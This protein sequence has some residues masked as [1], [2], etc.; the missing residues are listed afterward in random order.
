MEGLQFTI[1]NIRDIILRRKWIIVWSLI[2]CIAISV[3]LCFTLPKIYRAETLILVTSQKIPEDY[4]KPTVLAEIGERLATLQQ[5][6]FS[7]T[8]LEKI[9]DEFDLYKS[10]RATR[11]MESVIGTMRENIE[12][13]V[14]GKQSFTVV[15]YGRDPETV[16]N[17]TNKL[18]N[19]FIEEN[20]IQRERQARGTTEFL[21]QELEKIEEKLREQ[22]ET[23]SLFK[24]KYRGNLPE[25]LDFNLKVINNLI[26]EGET[27]N[28]A[29]SDAK[30]RKILLQEQLTSMNS[31]VEVVQ[32]DLGTKR[33]ISPQDP[34]KAEL[35]TA[36]RRLFELE[37][38]YTDEHPEVKRLRA[39]I[40]LLDGAIA[41]E[42]QPEG[43]SASNKR[44]P[45]SLYREI[46]TQIKNVDMEIA[47]LEQRVG[48]NRDKVT[49]Y[50]QRV[51]MAPRLEQDIIDITR[52]YDNKKR[53][54]QE[55]LN[56]KMVAEQA[57]NLELMKK[58]E[59]FEILDPA[60]WPERPVEPNRKKLITVGLLL[61][62]ALGSGL[63]YFMEYQNRSFYNTSEVEQSLELPVLASIPKWD[64]LIASDHQ[65]MAS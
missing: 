56:K 54:Y 47:R 65:K 26:A 37:S 61:G 38:I 48:N 13:E 15:Y 4:V 51:A 16:M 8:R 14:T 30:N 9:I 52:D 41:P 64:S 40:A 62:L 31:V 21:S 42:T 58:S 11:P 23:I 18:A 46:E 27:V 63:A 39:K 25:Q 60:H 10:L 2:P 24:A 20:L 12:L 5:E 34:A 32:D 36:Q 57:E 55:L 7:W 3:L 35:I 29:L 28:L 33:L 44:Q 6:I 59:Q 45:N 19:L 53:I 17:V 49:E 22:E 43:K 50:Q 1:D